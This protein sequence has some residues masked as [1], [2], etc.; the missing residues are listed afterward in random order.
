M[1]DL[2]NTHMEL[3]N[4]IAQNPVN[5]QRW[6][7]ALYIFKSVLHCTDWLQYWMYWIFAYITHDLTVDRLKEGQI[8]IRKGQLF[9]SLYQVS[10]KFL[11]KKSQSDFSTV[12]LDIL[13]EVTV[14]ES[15]YPEFSLASFFAEMGGSL[16]F[17]LGV[18]TMQLLKSFANLACMFRRSMDYDLNHIKK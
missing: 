18:D 13:Q 2:W 14:T 1:T 15:Y 17:W 9:K 11:N 4:Q 7:N 8:Q 3:Q 10:A 12:C 16:G 6:L 5:M